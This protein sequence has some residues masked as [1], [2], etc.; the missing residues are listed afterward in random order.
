MFGIAVYVIYMLGCWTIYYVTVRFRVW[1]AAIESVSV[2]GLAAIDSVEAR[3]AHCSALG[4]GLAD[5]LSTGS[6]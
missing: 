4:E 2:S 6:I 3:P 5:A 1:Q